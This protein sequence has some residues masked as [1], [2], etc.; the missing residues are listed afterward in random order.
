MKK[1]N[2][3]K[4]IINK[5]CEYLYFIGTVEAMDRDDACLQFRDG[6]YQND[7]LTARLAITYNINHYILL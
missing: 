4:L 3:Y 5:Y 6:E 2:V 1:F 7:F